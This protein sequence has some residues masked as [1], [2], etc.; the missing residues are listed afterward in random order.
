MSS[1]YRNMMDDLFAKAQKATDSALLMQISDLVKRGILVVEEEIPMM[2]R[3]ANSDEIIIQKV[4]KLSVKDMPYIKKLEDE[5]A[6]L[7]SYIND[8]SV[9]RKNQTT[10]DYNE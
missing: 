7:K 6:R 2:V 3:Q 5:N 8:W 4:V 1:S 9:A 10:E